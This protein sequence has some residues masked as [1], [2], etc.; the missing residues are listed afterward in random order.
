MAKE[1]S[2]KNILKRLHN[3]AVRVRNNKRKHN[4]LFQRIATLENS[5]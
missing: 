4:N 3:Q 5:K 2:E 1:K